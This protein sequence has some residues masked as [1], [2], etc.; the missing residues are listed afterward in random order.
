MFLYYIDETNCKVPWHFY[1]DEDDYLNDQWYDLAI[2]DDSHMIY[3]A[4]GP[5]LVLINTYEPSKPVVLN[6]FAPF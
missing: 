1:F 3:G 4:S 2:R 6:L 5:S